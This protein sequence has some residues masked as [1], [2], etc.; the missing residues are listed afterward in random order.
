M[1]IMRRRY[2]SGA[3]DAIQRATNLRSLNEAAVAVHRAGHV[4][5]IG[6]NMA[7]PIIEAAGS[8]GAAMTTS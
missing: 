3:A 1:W 2:R 8:S 4:P 7:L 5:I 6:V